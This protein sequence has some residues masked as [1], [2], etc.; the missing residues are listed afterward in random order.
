M[1][2]ETPTNQTRKPV[3][4]EL[5]VAEKDTPS[6]C[7]LAKPRPRT[8]YNASKPRDHPLLVTTNK[9]TR[10]GCFR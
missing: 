7:C 9:V 5:I 4:S 6:P 3:L 8:S 1:N 2:L 10:V